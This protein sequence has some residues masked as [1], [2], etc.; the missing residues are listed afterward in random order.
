MKIVLQRVLE[1]SVNID[2]AIFSEI[3]NGLLI[4]VGIEDADT[5]ED[6]VWL[7]NKI[8]NM[9]VFGD[10][11]GVMNRSVKDVSG[12]ILTVSQFTLQASV[13]KGHRPSYMKA[14]KAEISIPLYEQFVQQLQLDLGKEIKTGVFGADMKV[15]LVNDGPITIL[16][17]SKNRI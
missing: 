4:L 13:K 16:V 8:C 15:A 7:S 5:T 12:E 3:E 17:D 9:R 11:N 6:I 1:A 14:A 2:G 10:D